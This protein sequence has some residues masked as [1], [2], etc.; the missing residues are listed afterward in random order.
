MTDEEWSVYIKTGVIPETSTLKYRAKNF[1]PDNQQ[2]V[3]ELQR[4]LR[5]AGYYDGE[6]DGIFGVKSEKA[7]RSYQSDRDRT[8]WDIITNLIGQ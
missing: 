1:K 6:L 5:S 2:S 8:L 4:S 7:L 3:L